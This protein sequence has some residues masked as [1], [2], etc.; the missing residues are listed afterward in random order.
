MR[1]LRPRQS[2]CRGCGSRRL[3]LFDH[4]ASSKRICLVQEFNVLEKPK[5]QDNEHS[6]SPNMWSF[7]LNKSNRIYYL[8]GLGEDSRESDLEELMN[9]AVSIL[10]R[11]RKH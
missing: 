10:R 1:L 3:G 9:M 2:F 11:D 6:I 7:L 4:A 5:N 8:N